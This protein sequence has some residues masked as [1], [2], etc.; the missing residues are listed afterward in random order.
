M[1][2]EPEPEPASSA[3]QA[4]GIDALFTGFPCELVCDALVGGNRAVVASRRMD[5]GEQVLTSAALGF[6]IDR[7]HMAT[8]CAWCF[9]TREVNDEATDGSDDEDEDGLA[10]QL[11][12]ER[13][14]SAY[15]CSEA[16]QA[17]A[18]PQHH[19]ECAALRAIERRKQLKKEER[20][21]ARLLTSILGTLV[22]A[23]RAEP[24]PYPP[25]PTLDMLLDLFPDQRESVGAAKRAKQRL[26]AAK[27]VLEVGGDALLSVLPVADV[28]TLVACLD[29][30]PMN[31][32]G[33]WCA[34]GEAGS[35]GTAYYP[36]AAM[37]NH[38]CMPNVAHQFEGTGLVF[39]TVRPVEAGEPLCFAYTMPSQQ[40]TS[41]RHKVL[42]NSWCFA[43]RCPR[44]TD[45]L[46]SEEIR[47]YDT[48]YICSCGQA[49][50]PRKCLRPTGA[51]VGS[52]EMEIDLLVA[53]WAGS[54]GVSAQ[55][56]CCC[57]VWNMVT[58]ENQESGQSE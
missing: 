53:R 27:L 45:S 16:C 33:L 43:C 44:C 48:S 32:F 52:T 51:A 34:D 49:K 29:R 26:T 42:S 31:E 5:A 58:T 1:Q 50:I 28:A 36:A 24:F 12:C 10:W 38:S 7:R 18:T 6:A 13:C 56:V 21:L 15:Y 55:A 47:S 40:P 37:L 41:A 54:E 4:Q 25:R 23:N 9:A 57:N 30:G 3:Q 14:C 46:S 2:G 20:L 35:A 11:R 22:V 19:L 39:Y 17:A 8:R